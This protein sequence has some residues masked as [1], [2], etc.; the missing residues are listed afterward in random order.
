MERKCIEMVENIESTEK[1]YILFNGTYYFAVN[2]QKKTVKTMDINEAY[3]FN[4]PADA[5]HERQRRSKK[6]NGFHRYVFFSDGKIVK[7]KNRANERKQFSYE[8]RKEIFEKGNCKCYLCGKD[9]DFA[10][11]TVDHVHPFVKGGSNDISNLLPCCESCNLLKSNLFK[12]DFYNKMAEIIMYQ[13]EQSTDS[14]YKMNC[15]RKWLGEM[16]AMQ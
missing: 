8:K 7:M 12:S 5:K 1:G 10:R 16:V 9:L 4:S 13:M 11:F 3:I 6:L 2:E 15:M 14:D